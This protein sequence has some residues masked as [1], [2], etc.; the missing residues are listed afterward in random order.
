MCTLC[1]GGILIGKK[2]GFPATIAE[3][4]DPKRLREGMNKTGHMKG[5]THS[6]DKT[7]IKRARWLMTNWKNF[8]FL[9]QLYT[10]EEE[11]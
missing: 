5:L 3:V 4:L 1:I 2:S 9:S 6:N 11:T 7:H 10:K 8:I